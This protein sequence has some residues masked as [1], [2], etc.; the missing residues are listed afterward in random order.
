MWPSRG[1][2][3]NDPVKENAFLR[4]GC[5][6]HLEPVVLRVSAAK[7]YRVWAGIDELEQPLVLFREAV[8]EDEAAVETSEE[9]LEEGVE[10]EEEVAEV[11]EEEETSETNEEDEG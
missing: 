10:A 2:C 9:P 1:H 11:N 7:Q 4:G 8:V 3:F 6:N 5:V